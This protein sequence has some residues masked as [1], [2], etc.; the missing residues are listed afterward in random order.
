M[1]R[2]S[3]VLCVAAFAMVASVVSAAE[4]DEESWMFKLQKRFFKQ[5]EPK[6][7]ATQPPP[8]A[9]AAAAA[10]ERQPAPAAA[11]SRTTLK[12]MTAPELIAEINEM[13]DDESE[14]ISMIQGLSQGQDPEGNSYYLYQGSRMEALNR[15]LLEK[16]AT[17]IA[18]ERTRLRTERINR[19]L[20]TIRNAQRA[21]DI[22]RQ[23][24]RPPTPPAQPPQAPPAPPSTRIPQAPQQPPQTRR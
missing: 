21:A 15:D 19:Q 3:I 5:E 7:A 1:K 23:A 11:T 18:Q 22:A 20:E 6:A 12:D 4:V 13:L 8:K 14:I 24:S 17:R 16:L 10:K 9:G 2:L